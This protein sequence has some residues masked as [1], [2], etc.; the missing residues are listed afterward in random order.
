[1]NRRRNLPKPAIRLDNETKT[2]EKRLEELKQSMKKEKEEEPT[3]GSKDGLL[4]RILTYRS[5]KSKRKCQG[6]KKNYRRQI[7]GQRSWEHQ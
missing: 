6:E 5:R 4:E 7:S 2:I 1:M 3:V